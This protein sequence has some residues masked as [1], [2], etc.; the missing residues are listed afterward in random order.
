MAGLESIG[1]ER[2][3]VFRCGRTAFS[4]G[5]QIDS[6][7]GGGNGKSN[8]GSVLSI[9]EGDAVVHHLCGTLLFVLYLSPI[10]E[11]FLFSEL[12]VVD[13]FVDLNGGG[14]HFFNL[15]LALL[16]KTDNRI[17]K[18]LYVSLDFLKR[19]CV[20]GVFLVHVILHI[21]GFMLCDEGVDLTAQAVELGFLGCQVHRK[22]GVARRVKRGKNS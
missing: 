22:E 4:L 16:R 7:K 20:F 5:E 10:I 11:C 18:M 12:G 13:A 15:G 19:F 17:G 1:R 14:V 21:L 6:E 3:G 9:V 8:I 2:G